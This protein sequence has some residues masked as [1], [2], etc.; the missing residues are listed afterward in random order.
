MLGDWAKLR[1]LIEPIRRRYA[2]SV[3][4]REQLRNDGA[5]RTCTVATTDYAMQYIGYW[6]SQATV[7]SKPNKKTWQEFGDKLKATPNF[8][9]KSELISLSETVVKAAFAAVPQA[10][11]GMGRCS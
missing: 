4:G 1:D 7:V 11:P 8:E 9:I 10:T 6:D 2:R 3:I 5:Y